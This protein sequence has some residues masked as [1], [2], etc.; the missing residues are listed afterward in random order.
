ML[1]LSHAVEFLSCSNDVA[2]ALLPTRQKFSLPVRIYNYEF[3]FKRFFFSYEVFSTRI[4]SNLR[5]LFSQ[6]VCHFIC[7]INDAEIATIG[8]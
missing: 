5:L 7:E 8:E 2:I 1:D 6:K 3:F 4:F